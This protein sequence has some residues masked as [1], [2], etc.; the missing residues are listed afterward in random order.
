MESGLTEPPSR[1]RYF[2][3]VVCALYGIG[4]F[5]AFFSIGA[6]ADYSIV[7]QGVEATKIVIAV[8]KSSIG[9]LVIAIVCLLVGSVTGGIL[10]ANTFI[11][12][13]RLSG[14]SPPPPVLDVESTSD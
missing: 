11:M 13:R 2:F 6:R 4:G 9:S 7:P 10:F 8:G 1:W 12:R 14:S 3:G 5:I